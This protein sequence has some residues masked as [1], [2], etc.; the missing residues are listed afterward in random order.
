MP[1]LYWGF[2]LAHLS[3]LCIII[4]LAVQMVHA[5]SL[6]NHSIAPYTVHWWVDLY[7]THPKQKKYN[8]SNHEYTTNHT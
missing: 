7:F 5:P 2:C 3:G 8:K 1:S 6:P 4:L